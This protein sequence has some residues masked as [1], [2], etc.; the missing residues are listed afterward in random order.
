[1]PIF[2][3]IDFLRLEKLMYN[4][5]LLEK[6]CDPYFVPLLEIALNLI[7]YP[8]KHIIQQMKKGL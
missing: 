7:P 8:K 3:G 5:F 2:I 4:F 1:M 6:G